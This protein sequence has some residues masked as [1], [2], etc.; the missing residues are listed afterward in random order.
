MKSRGQIGRG[1]IPLFE[2]HGLGQRPA[3]GSSDTARAGPFQTSFV[4]TERTPRM[5]TLDDLRFGVLQTMPAP[6]ETVTRD[7]SRA[8]SGGRTK[9]VMA[10]RRLRYLYP[11]SR[12]THARI[13]EDD[14]GPTH[15]LEQGRAKER[16]TAH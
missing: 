7:R 5:T 6:A 1:G 10:G 2:G 4:R 15:D 9:L 12:A 16:R 8:E 14:S 13:R 11:S 3:F